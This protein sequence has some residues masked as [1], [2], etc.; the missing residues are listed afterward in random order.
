MDV[1]HKATDPVVDQLYV[2]APLAF[3]LYTAYKVT[4]EKM[5]KDFFHQIMDFLVRIQIR[6]KD[7][8]LNGAWMRAF[9]YKNWDYYG[10]NGDIDWGPYCVESGWTNTWIGTTLALYLMDKTAI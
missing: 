1:T 2:N 9:D 7:K 3:C 6:S 10:S 5:Y 8:K 4:G